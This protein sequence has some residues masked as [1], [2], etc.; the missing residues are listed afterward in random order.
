VTERSTADDTTNTPPSPTDRAE[1]NR[2]GLGRRCGQERGKPKEHGQATCDHSPACRVDCAFRGFPGT[3]APV[4]FLAESRD[5]EEGV[6]DAHAETDH[7]HDGQHEYRH[8]VEAGGHLHQPEGDDDG[9]D[10][11]DERCD[12]RD[13]RS[14]SE[15]EDD[16][17]ER[18][19]FAFPDPRVLFA[20]SAYVIVERWAAGHLHV[21]RGRP[22]D[23]VDRSVNG[24]AE[25]RYVIRRAS[26]EVVAGCGDEE[27]REPI[28][29]QEHRVLCREERRRLADVRLPCRR[30]HQR[31]EDGLIRK[32]VDGHGP[33]HRHDE[34]VRDGQ[35]KSLSDECPSGL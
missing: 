30:T 4:H 15:H 28:R 25:R 16:R 18:E 1:P 31:I 33:V 7:R 5:H 13:Q 2:P 12:R 6:V 34:E 24:V 11:N 23:A 35:S 9:E 21:V 19:G 22:R 32:T 27:R 8:R 14:E 10:P 20:H 26:I 17:T 3:T 29:A